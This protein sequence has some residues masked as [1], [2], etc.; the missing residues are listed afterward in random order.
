[1]AIAPP[2]PLAAPK[3]VKLRSKSSGPVMRSSVRPK[4]AY[5]RITARIVQNDNKA[6]EIGM[7]DR[8]KTCH[9]ELVTKRSG[10]RGGQ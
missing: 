4:S 10:G 2:M 7:D 3:T 1:L 8:E 9:T 6:W 5:E